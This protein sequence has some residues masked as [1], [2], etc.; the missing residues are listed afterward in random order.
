[1]IKGQKNLSAYCTYVKAQI[2]VLTCVNTIGNSLPPMVI[3][4]RQTFSIE[5]ATGEIPGTTYGF[6]QSGWID[7]DSFDKWFDKYF[8]L[9]AP[10]ARPLFCQAILPIITLEPN[11]KQLKIKLL[12]LYYPQTL[13][14]LHNPWIKGVLGH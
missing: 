5:L 13:L 11:V 9:Y 8:L 6:S 12:F 1:M 10:A 3:F 2:T 7:Q 14:T 4:D